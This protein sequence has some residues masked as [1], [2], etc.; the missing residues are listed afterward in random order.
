MFQEI[1]EAK[2]QRRPSSS[3]RQFPLRYNVRR[4]PPERTWITSSS[5][6]VIFHKMPPSGSV[7]GFFQFRTGP[8][9]NSD[10]LMSP[11]GVDCSVSRSN[12]SSSRTSSMRMGVSPLEDHAIRR[13]SPRFSI[14]DVWRRAFVFVS[15]GTR[16]CLRRTERAFNGLSDPECFE[17]KVVNWRTGKER[18][19][20]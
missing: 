19:L 9:R 2:S 14:A 7:S 1:E 15:P 4:R 11:F 17:A 6:K 5:P 16:I 13:E 20:E 3:E 8:W 18:C 12:P 10:L